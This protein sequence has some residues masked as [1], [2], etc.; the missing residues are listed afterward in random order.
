[1][2]IGWKADGTL[3]LEAHPALME[4]TVDGEAVAV[5]TE[6]VD[7]APADEAPV[8][9]SPLTSLMRAYIA[10]TEVRRVDL[11]WDTAERVAQ[12]GNGI[13]QAVSVAGSATPLATEI[14]AATP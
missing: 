11:D 8:Q 2:K 4:S 3:Y 13:P 12:F 14:A 1:V 7:A 9:E 5:A 6:V 10:A